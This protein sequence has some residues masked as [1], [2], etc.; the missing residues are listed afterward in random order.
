MIKSW[1]VGDVSLLQHF[2]SKHL[3]HQTAFYFKN[4]VPSKCFFLHVSKNIIGLA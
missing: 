1:G 4:T 2:C 3:R